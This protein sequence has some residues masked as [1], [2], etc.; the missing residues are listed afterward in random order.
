MDEPEIPQDLIETIQQHH[1]LAEGE[2]IAEVERMIGKI[3]TPKVCH[4]TDEA[5]LRGILESGRIWQTDIFSQTDISELRHGLGFA[6]NAVAAAAEQ[7]DAKNEVKM[8]AKGF[9]HFQTKLPQSANY[10]I[11]CFG[12]V[13]NDLGNW[14]EFAGDGKGY[15]LVFDRAALVRA[16]VA[17]VVASEFDRLSFPVTYDDAAIDRLQQRIMTSTLPCLSAPRAR[18][19]SIDRLV[20]L[21]FMTQASSCISILAVRA[22]LLFK[23]EAF[24]KQSE[25]RLMELHPEPPVSSSIKTPP[26]GKRYAE[27]DWRSHEPAA[28]R[29]II[30]GPNADHDAAK[31]IASELVAKTCPIQSVAVTVSDIPYRH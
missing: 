19:E 28:L 30:V 23:N 3:T 31:R 11:A 22:A 5:G 18:A 9:A 10:F 26:S 2:L 16:H 27:F 21:Q 1:D 4:Y 25:F 14:I 7:A 8:F 6:N 24:K 13:P 12:S 29:E 20:A 17:G 15:G